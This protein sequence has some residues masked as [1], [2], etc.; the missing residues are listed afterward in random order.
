MAQQIEFFFLGILELAVCLCPVFY[1]SFFLAQACSSIILNT[2]CSANATGAT[3][4]VT[5]LDGKETSTYACDPET[6]QWTSE[7]LEEECP[8]EVVRTLNRNRLKDR[9]EKCVVYPRFWFTVLE[10]DFNLAFNSL[11]ESIRKSLPPDKLKS[12]PFL[13]SWNEKK[14]TSALQKK[15]KTAI[16]L[17]KQ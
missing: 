17:P 9:G 6:N 15:T 4:E 1:L 7:V 16:F 3:C 2:W 14:F 12:C 11:F 5:C 10:N 13:D 8:V